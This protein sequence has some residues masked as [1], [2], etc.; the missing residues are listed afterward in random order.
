M[1]KCC[2]GSWS[3]PIDR[4]AKGQRPGLEKELIGLAAIEI[5]LYHQR[6]KE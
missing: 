4:L 5:L 2:G 1:K 6:K 3:S